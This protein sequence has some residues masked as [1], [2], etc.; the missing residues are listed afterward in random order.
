MP[1]YLGKYA[2]KTARRIPTLQIRVIGPAAI[3]QAIL[4]DRTNLEA[5]SGEPGQ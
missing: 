1:D 4:A 2:A 5:Y 3:A